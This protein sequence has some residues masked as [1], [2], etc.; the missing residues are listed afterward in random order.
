[1]HLEAVKNDLP[2]LEKRETH[3]AMIALMRSGIVIASIVILLGA[4]YYAINFIKFVLPGLSGPVL[5]LALLV[6]YLALIWYASKSPDLEL[7]DPNA[8]VVE[9]PIAREVIRTGLHYLL[10]LFVL[11][12]SLM[13]E[14][15]SP[16]LSAFYA[17][18]LLIVIIV[19]QKPLKALFRGLQSAEQRAAFKE[20][21]DDLVVG[22]ILGARNM[23]GIA[24]A[25]ATTCSGLCAWR[26]D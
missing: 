9:L 5:M 19:T 6:S 24:L 4:I 1:M 2:V 26:S 16:G 15:K 25:T 3:P 17:V 23:I 8:P 13:V 20:G 18:L 10:P 7:D 14:R 11:V 12:W 21:F 22:L